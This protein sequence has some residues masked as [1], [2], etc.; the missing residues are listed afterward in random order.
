[1]LPD[2][3]GPWIE[4]TG[5]AGDAKS[6]QRLFE[7]TLKGGFEESASLRALRALN[8][9]A[10]RGVRPTG[11]LEEI[12]RLLPGETS[13][14][15][16]EMITEVLRLIGSWKLETFVPQLVAFSTGTTGS[17]RQTAMDS[18]REIGGKAAISA[19]EPLTGKEQSPAIRRQAVLALAAIDLEKATRPAT[20]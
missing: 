9:A 18:L 20:E 11:S 10:Q 5:T 4:L 2:G 1:I 17:L 16:S 8:V 13:S 3:G 7:Q 19:L 15:K 12:G 14:A 6:L